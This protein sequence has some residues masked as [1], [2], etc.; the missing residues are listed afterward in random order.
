M[1]PKDQ[2]HPVSIAYG[3]L[4]QA[5]QRNSLLAH[6]RMH[7]DGQTLIITDADTRQEVYRV[8]QRWDDFTG[9]TISAV[10]AAWLIEQRLI[11]PSD[12]EG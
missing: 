12:L 7:E 1:Q 11:K 5:C 9:A 10:A 8:N 6:L 2:A 3:N 4:L